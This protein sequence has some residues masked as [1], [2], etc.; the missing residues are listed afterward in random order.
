V[1]GLVSGA[2][3][4]PASAALL[5]ELGPARLAARAQARLAVSALALLAVPEPAR[6]AGWVVLEGRVVPE[7]AVV[8]V[9]QVE[10]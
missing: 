4:V 3:A 9:A 2:L 1:E 5:G 10:V 6:P 8:P 7:V